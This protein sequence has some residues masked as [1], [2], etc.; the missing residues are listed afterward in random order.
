V[1]RLS[2]RTR[3]RAIALGILSAILVAVLLLALDAVL[4]ARRMLG[5]ISRARNDLIDGG[6][7]V[8]TGD[9]AASIPFFKAADKAA[10]SAVA[11]AGH[12]GIRLM[13]GLPWIGDN[14]EAVSAV[15]EA[16]RE[17][18]QA[19]LSMADA[20]IT[21][22][23][24]D[25]RLPGT[26]SLGDL[27]LGAIEAATP[28]IDAVA[29]QLNDAVDR[30]SAAGSS[31]LLG[32]VASGYDDAVAV[33]TRRADL[34]GNARDLFHLLPRLFGGIGP[35][36]YLLAVESLGQPQG[37]GGR[38]GPVGVM[39]A[40]D[41]T[42]SLDPLAPADPAL[43]N[44]LVS[45]NVPVGARAML[46]AAAEQGIP[47]LDGVILVDTAG[48]QDLLW[49]V[50]D[51]E[52]VD[53]PDP[54][55]QNDTV[56][57]LDRD[58]FVS[59]ALAEAEVLQAS[60]AGELLDEALTRR[61]ST[62]AF[63]TAMAQMVSGRHLAL[64]ATDPKAQKLLDRLGATGLF[65]P[66]GNLLSVA[67][68]TTGTNRTGTFVRRPLSVAITLDAGGTAALRMVMDVT[69]EARDG[70]PSAL[71][72][73]PFTEHPVGSF[74]GTADVYLPAA[75]DHLT[76]ETSPPG[77][78]DTGKDLGVPVASAA[79]SLGP[80]NSTSVTVTARV[81]D[82]AT[83]TG[84]SWQYVIRIVPQ[85]SATPQPLRVLVRLPSGMSVT[86]A[87]D[88]MESAGTL[89]RYVGAPDGTLTLFVR[90]R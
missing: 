52:V 38:V 8:V 84:T 43:A 69:N 16:S 19:G 50:G 34:A 26:S 47:G 62:E 27:D 54:L 49:M 68:D 78:T 86:S 61:P 5:D 55:T 42:L 56:S 88:E 81:V 9:P 77:Q 53:L 36:R 10:G 82:A 15:A 89:A 72:G 73:H 65:D 22:G 90:Y 39:T 14:I 32:P 33:L 46:A 67:L 7:S 51:V 58:V 35:R 24:A 13:R 12:P 40:A 3:R 20:A 63:G 74:S 71:L 48:L 11:A 64:Y 45:P 75:A 60:I 41:G 37:P 17:T 70:P 80:G 23:W 57:T 29:D 28:K 59:N 44:A 21:L 83:R 30:L 18:A 4:S 31:H 66:S 85:P 2:H 1:N 79:L 76:I 6:N 25:L 87:S